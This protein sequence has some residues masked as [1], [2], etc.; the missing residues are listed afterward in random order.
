MPAYSAAPALA[1]EA[2]LRANLREALDLQASVNL[3]VEELAAK[4]SVHALPLDRPQLTGV[5]EQA[6]ELV[7]E[8]EDSVP[9][10]GAAEVLTQDDPWH[11]LPDPSRTHGEPSS[12]NLVE[13]QGEIITL[14]DQEWENYACISREQFR[15]IFC[16][17]MG[18]LDIAKVEAET[19]C[20]QACSGATH[21]DEVVE[22][23][24]DD[25]PAEAGPP[26]PQR[27]GSVRNKVFSVS[28][29]IV[30]ILRWHRLSKESRTLDI[31]F[32]S[33]SFVSLGW[34]ERYTGRVET[35]LLRE[36]LKEKDKRN[37]FRFQY[38]GI[39]GRPGLRLRLAKPGWHPAERSKPRRSH[40]GHPRP[41]PNI[42]NEDSYS[43]SESEG[44]GESR[45]HWQRQDWQE[46]AQEG[47][48]SHSWP[49]AASR[50]GQRLLSFN[51]RRGPIQ[52][53]EQRKRPAP[54]LDQDQESG[55]EA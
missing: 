49:E 27:M 26:R 42:F 34:L 33:E 22:L 17:L 3:R 9:C 5:Q 29:R 24:D 38:R 50:Q 16:S 30:T 51:E 43:Q 10:P 37:Q 28:K 54:A 52:A 55:Q 48:A 4:I 18:Q 1:P 53:R 40:R 25:K 39:L 14:L 45:F 46:G 6:E 32:D 31:P 8:P 11:S 19:N 15:S 20:A 47:G 12:E 41:N 2:S 36:I 7:D 44:R 21:Q 23:S 13:F 35:E